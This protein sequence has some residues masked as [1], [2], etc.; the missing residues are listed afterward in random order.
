MVTMVIYYLVFRLFCKIAI[1]LVY[2]NKIQNL[3]DT[4]LAGDG[5]THRADLQS[6]A[7]KK[8]SRNPLKV[9]IARANAAG[10]MV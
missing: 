9:R 6:A 3:G 10:I 4:S 2:L 8:L 1:K 5:G 7:F